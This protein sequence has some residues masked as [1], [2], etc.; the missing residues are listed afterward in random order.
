MNMQGV[1]FYDPE[2]VG[3]SPEAVEWRGIQNL[4]NA[5]EPSLS[6]GGSIPLFDPALP[7][8]TLHFHMYEQHYSAHQLQ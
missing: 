8:G 4:I 6:Q 3:S 5:A 7:V 2:V 1:K